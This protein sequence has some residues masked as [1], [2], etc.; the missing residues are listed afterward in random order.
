MAICANMIG[1]GRHDQ[2][3]GHRLPL[4]ALLHGFRQL[5][6]ITSGIVERIQHAAIRQ[7]NRIIEGAR[8]WRDRAGTD[9]SGHGLTLITISSRLQFEPD[10]GGGDLSLDR[11]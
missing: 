6:G 9:A 1:L 8:P 2:H 5:C 7:R 10:A 11:E 4:G 3:L